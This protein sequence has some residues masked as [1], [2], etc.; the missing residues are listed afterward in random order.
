QAQEEKTKH[1]AARLGQTL[2]SITDAFLTVDTEWRFSF[3]NTEAERLLRRS[4]GDLLG[5]K[6]WSE[7]PEAVGSVFQKEYERALSDRI[8]V[9]FEAFYPPLDVWFY[10]RA[11]PSDQ[12]LAVYF[13][14]I[15]TE[16][17]AADENQRF[18]ANLVDIVETLQDVGKS[19]VTRIDVLNMLT[20][21]AQ[22]LT[23]ASGA[24]VEILVNGH[25]ECQA[26]T[27]LIADKVGVRVPLTTGLSGLVMQSGQALVCAHA[28]DDSRVDREAC[29]RA[30]VRSL[31]V[32]P[33]RNAAGTI[34]VL[35]VTSE[36]SGAF[37]QRDV[38]NLEI[39]AAS[40]GAA[41]QRHQDAERLRA[42][43]AQ[44]RMLFADNPYPM[45]T[46]DDQSFQILVANSAAMR[47]YGYTESEFRNLTFHDLGA[48]LDHSPAPLEVT[49]LS[50]G[51]YSVGRVQHRTRQG[52]LFDVEIT[53]NDVLFEGRH[54]RLL[55]IHDVTERVRAENAAARAKRALLMHSRCT[56]TLIRTMDEEELL[57]GV[58]T[59]AV[60]A[61]GFAMAWVGYALDDEKRTIVPRA[62]AGAAQSYLSQIQ[63]SW[64]ADDPTGGG[65]A[66]IAIRTGRVAIAAD[67]AES[68]G[69]F[70]RE[71][72]LSHGFQGVVAV[73]LLDNGRAFGLLV[74]Y[75]KERV[76]LPEE[77]IRVLQDVAD[78][79][80]F[81]IRNL[82]A[83]A[84][85]RRT[86]DA[87]LAL[88]RG[89]SSA[90]G[91]DFFH[92]LTRSMMEALGG[93]AGFVAKVDP[94]RHGFTTTLCAIEG[95]KIAPDFA[96]DLAR[97]PG[98]DY[99]EAGL[100]MITRDA[101][102][103]SPGW[104]PLL[105]GRVDAFVGKKL[106]DS[107]GR[108]VGLMVV[109][110]VEPLT[111]PEF[112]SSILQ[113][114]AAR[115]ASEIER[116]AAEAKTREQAALLDK[117]RDAIILRDLSHRITYWNK[118]AETLY[119][120]TAAEAIGRSVVGLLYTQPEQFHRAQ[121]QL[122]IAG[123]WTGELT[124]QTKTGRLLAVEG[125]WTLVR[126]DNGKPRSVLAINTDISERKA[127]EQQL[128]RSQRLESIGTLAGGIAHDLNNLLAPITMGVDM[129]RRD[130][131]LQTRYGTIIDNIK[132]SSDRGANLVRQVLSFARGVESDKVVLNVRHIIRE[133]ESMMETLFP[134][135][136]S[137]SVT[138]PYDL[139]PIVADPTQLNQVLLNLCVNARDA[140][141]NGGRLTITARE[142]EVDAQYA[143]TN[144]LAKPGRFLAVDV[145]DN[146]S[147]MTS[148]VLARIFEPFYTTKEFGKGT[149]LGLATALSI[150][151][152]HGGFIDVVSH[153]G[154]GSTF[155]VYLPLQPGLT[156]SVAT[157]IDSDT[158]PMGKGELIL[159]VD[160]E[161]T[162]REVTRKT[163]EASGYEVIT[164]ED[165]AQAISLYAEN[166][167]RVAV[168]LTDMMMPVMDGA[169]L[170]R[171][172]RRLDMSVR[173]IAASGFDGRGQTVAASHLGIAHILAKPYSAKAL[174]STLRAALESEDHAKPPDSS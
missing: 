63:L 25:M 100:W 162:I 24:I 30:G 128:L 168:V 127:M 62:F 23:G 48:S 67:V 78:D 142:T 59:I 169:A 119:G 15:T 125:R 160:D 9:G 150:V 154:R 110:F 111:R 153:A 132:R 66:G 135:N 11:Y 85:R 13:R 121:Q 134:K 74:L 120:W 143:A 141:P 136:I 51:A 38:K 147:G 40:L 32:V 1:L 173:V 113:V 27:G 144:Q 49:E 4:R 92:Q 75:L 65:P 45:I 122:R 57:K 2:E 80:A 155:S 174:L 159:I 22:A 163:L 12:G 96:C 5:R 112:A 90:A 14:D 101:R 99:E 172:L 6:I 139:P 39:L 98:D 34:G 19:D 115:A 41:I 104:Q 21:R 133:V 103:H 105:P 107:E 46:V 3:L 95:D 94:D 86:H 108:L 77:E 152:S 156:E 151:R 44:Y 7:F 69:F 79:L 8:T 117:A 129:L 137:V 53:M 64:S 76:A 130:Q 93:A 82:Q 81:G 126:D 140:M 16:R 37:T 31:A 171:A 118:S 138:V 36:K 166:R 47:R 10:V 18:S 97:L 20:Q 146:G 26:A 56:E 61:G 58:C 43:E 68:D 124:H 50:R 73:P 161:P 33:L 42:S 72:A 116:Q 102:R 87:V 149:G 83:R 145:T 164:A 167:D 71:E 84:E 54:A 157:T 17:R 158:L 70:F 55:H 114:F 60:E 170:V 106:V 89:I 28:E 165:G 88:A 109:L 52:E 123:E 91:R 148:D 29:A 35:K 131:T